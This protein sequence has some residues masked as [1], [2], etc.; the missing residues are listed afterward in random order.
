FSDEDGI[1]LEISKNKDK[2]SIILR[3]FNSSNKK[4]ADEVMRRLDEMSKADPFQYYVAKMREST[5]RKGESAGLGL[6]RI[7]YETKADLSAIYH[8][9]KNHNVGIL[10]IKSVF[11]LD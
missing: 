11:A 8:K 7:Q 6:A 5:K 2:N 4:L 10:E 3:V 1:R 9:R